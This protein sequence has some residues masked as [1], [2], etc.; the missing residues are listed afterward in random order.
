VNVIASEQGLPAST[1]SVPTG[2]QTNVLC[3]VWALVGIAPAEA[4]MQIGKDSV[5]A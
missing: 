2:D 3:A 5:H 1:S 4:L